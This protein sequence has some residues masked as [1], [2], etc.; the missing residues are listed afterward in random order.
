M[1]RLLLAMACGA[2]VA[3]A[4]GCKGDKGDKGPPGPAGEA[5][6]PGPPG[7]SAVVDAGD[8]A[9][10]L[11]AAPGELTTAARLGLELA[12][13]LH[14]PL[15]GRTTADLEAIGYGSYLVNAVAACNDCHQQV[16]PGDGG[17]PT[18]NYLGGGTEFDIPVGGGFKVFSRN[19][20]SDPTTGLK[21]TEDQ[22]VQVFQTG[23]DFKGV[24]AGAAP[25]TSLVVM[26]WATFRWMTRADMHAVYSFLKVVPAVSNMV[27]ADVNRPAIPPSPAPT[28]YDEGAG[29]ARPLPPETTPDP[30][31]VARGIAMQPVPIP[32]AVFGLMTIGQQAQFGRGAYLVNAV[33]GCNDCHTNPDRDMTNKINTA[34]YLSGGRVFDIA[35]LLGPTGPAQTGITRSMTANLTGAVHGFFAEPDVTFALFQSIIMEGKHVD[36]T[37]PAPLAPPMPWQTYR[38]MLSED[39]AAVY[40]YISQVPKRTGAN[41]KLTQ[42]PARFCA[43]GGP[44][45]LPGETCTAGE[46]TG[47]GC[48]DNANC[49][50]CQPCGAGADGGVS[51]CSS[52]PV[53]L[54]DGGPACVA[55]GI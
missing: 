53:P 28:A 38:N 20:T 39:L 55:T 25:T 8:A 13:P 32:D 51:S 26:P 12:A 22:F 19:L 3:A 31:N 33:A 50:A 47:G 35:S 11:A 36:D 40:Q 42:P 41:D 23:A 24:A 29:G 17:P 14:L 6:P 9:Q 52:A 48:T 30:G 5:G 46:C 37:P 10:D 44:S 18:I 21:L 34:A 4:G 2:A 45:C 54:P 16:V 49:G 7:G 15:A 27:M 43:A 1:R